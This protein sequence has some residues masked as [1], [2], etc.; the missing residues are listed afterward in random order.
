MANTTKKELEREVIIA[1]REYGI[2]T[3][4]F[5]HI[6]GK[7]LGVNV[8]D[9]ECLAVVFFKG[10]ATPT[11]LAKYTGLS[12]GATT[13][14]LDR[15]ERAGLIERRPNPHDR[16]GTLIAPKEESKQKVGPLFT[17]I[18]KKQDA[19]MVG[20]SQK[21]LQIILDFLSKTAAA[22]DEERRKLQPQPKGHNNG[23]SK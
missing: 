20:Y 22:W 17:P 11:E 12:S 2:S 14:M 8:T 13:A 6:V 16:R 7:R 18:R 23:N 10:I 21:E 5:R 19:L 3:V 15:L 1:A 9:M 4:L